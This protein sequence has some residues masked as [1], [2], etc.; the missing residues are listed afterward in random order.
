MRLKPFRNH[1]AI[2][3][4]EFVPY[5]HKYVYAKCY[6]IQL[7]FVYHCLDS[8]L[9]TL[10]IDWTEIQPSYKYDMYVCRSQ[11]SGLLAIVDGPPQLRFP[12]R[13]LSQ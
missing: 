2:F 6:V 8:I 9:S 11:R 5:T 10:D 12:G 3:L 1:Q 13:V 7:K 4:I